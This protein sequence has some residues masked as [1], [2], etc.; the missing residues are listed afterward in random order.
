MIPRAPPIFDLIAYF[1]NLQAVDEVAVVLVL[2]QYSVN[3]KWSYAAKRL[4]VG[5]ICTKYS[6]ADR[7]PYG[8]LQLQLL[9]LPLIITRR[10]FLTLVFATRTI[11]AAVAV[12]TITLRELSCRHY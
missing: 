7:Y 2:Q 3:S 11:P 4:F 10:A 1:H 9:Q 5:I 6:K 8:P 12:V